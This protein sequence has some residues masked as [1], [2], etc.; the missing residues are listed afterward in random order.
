LLQIYN[1]ACIFGV[2]L[3]DSGTTAPAIQSGSLV[4]AQG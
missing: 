2:F 3:I 1:S 4:M